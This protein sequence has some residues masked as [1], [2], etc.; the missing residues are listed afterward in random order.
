MASVEGAPA[1]GMGVLVSTPGFLHSPVAIVPPAR[2]A[3]LVADRVSPEGAFSSARQKERGLQ[4]K[5]PRLRRKEMWI[6]QSEV[7]D[8]QKDSCLTESCLREK[9]C[10]LRQKER[11]RRQRERRLR[12]EGSAHGGMCLGLCGKGICFEN[13]YFSPLDFIFPY[14]GLPNKLSWFNQTKFVRLKV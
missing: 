12:H 1:S 9:E 2:G 4:Q 8:L 10:C 3:L 7:W 6:R 14:L 5:G 13:P 11:R